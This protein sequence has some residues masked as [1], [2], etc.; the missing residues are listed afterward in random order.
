M[1]TA[2][3]PRRGVALVLV[4]VTLSI[5]FVMAAFSMNVA[6]MQL[7]RTELRA[8]T[9]AAARAGT[10][11]LA[12]LDS[13]AAAVQ[14]AINVAAANKING[15][16]LNLTAAD[17][18]LG[19]ASVS[20]SGQWTF[21][22]GASPI[23]AVRVNADKVTPLI[24]P[25]VT[26]VSSFSPSRTATAAFAETEICLVVD[27]SHSM[28][29]DFSGVDWAYP[30]GIPAAPPDQIIYPPHPSDSR[31]AALDYA[32]DQFL[33]VIQTNNATQSVSLVTW[34]SEITLAHYEG[35]LTGRTFPMSALDVPLTTN[36][37]AISTAITN[38][39]NDIMLGGTNVSAG[40]DHGVQVL[41]GAGTHDYASKIMILM[42]DGQW[43]EGRSPLEA[44]QDAKLA[45]ITIHTVT[46]L[47][48]ANQQDMIDV[49]L[50]TGGR[51]FHA[52]DAAALTSA[53]EEIA[54]YLDVVLI[55]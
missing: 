25:G 16:P 30:A 50:A 37:S 53:F 44:A 7:V 18:Q 52:S 32:V 55:D 12:R 46:L 28:C 3:Q 1:R 41:T 45:N 9:D 20:P 47:D 27:R 24:L 34:G 48:S 29:F 19:A 13:Q 2:H 39:G 38:R 10:E 8:A 31:W 26:G 11:A 33:S 22:P 54:R 49:A 6:Y 5:F 40:I 14:A 42:T 15:E 4:L 51:H 17:I 23:S 36:L 21:Q 35:S 43:N